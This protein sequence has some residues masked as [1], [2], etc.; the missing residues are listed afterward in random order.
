MTLK[1]SGMV[2]G[3]VSEAVVNT[4][5]AAAPARAVPFKE[6]CKVFVA[7]TLSPDAGDAVPE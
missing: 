4:C 1:T 2:C 7:G 3:A 5:C 6:N